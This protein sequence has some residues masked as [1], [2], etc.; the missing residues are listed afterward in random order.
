MV[1]ALLAFIVYF[2]LLTL[3]QAWV[4][5]GKLSSGAGLVGIHGVVMAATLIALWWRDGSWRRGT[6]PAA[7]GA[8]A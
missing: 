5:S 3:S 7:E 8:R 2:N 1:W 4:S 6:V